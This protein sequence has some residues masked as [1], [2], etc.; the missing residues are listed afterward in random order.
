MTLKRACAVLAVVALSTGL[1][2]CDNPLD[3]PG[4]ASVSV[5]LTDL[6]GDVDALWIDV[7]RIYLQP[8][9][10]ADEGEEDD[11]Q[12]RVDLVTEATGYMEITSLAGTTASL[13][14]GVEISAGE[15]AQLRFVVSHAALQTEDGD[16]YVTPGSPLPEDA[17][18]TV[19][20]E[21]KC[22]SCTGP[23]GL[24]VS[25]AGGTIR[26]LEGAVTLLL[27]FDA[28]RSVG[29]LAGN[30]GMWVM[31]PLI[32]MSLMEDA[33]KVSGQV[34]LADGVTI[35]ECPAG[36]A[37]TLA[38]F[39]PTATANTLTDGEGDPVVVTGAANEAG[40]A[41]VTPLEPD[42]Y[43]LGFVSPVEFD[44]GSL[45]FA[46]DVEPAEVEIG[47][48]EIVTGARWTVTEATCS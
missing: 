36:E 28:S 32:R 48:G 6:P 38:D 16:V 35:P 8:F 17:T 14:E 11:D 30:S 33:G 20:G 47:A 5:H 29:R 37:R 13:V 44:G 1:W 18:G 23:S 19:A 15:Y 46:A 9:D 22:P 40:Q 43:T 21:L 25:A 12:G 45:E 4:A 31:N 24:K 3:S 7:S 42:T 10:D 27:D 2:A 34:T 39:M 26:I 41:F